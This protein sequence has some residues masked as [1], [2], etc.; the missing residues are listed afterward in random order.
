MFKQLVQKKIVFE[1]FEVRRCRL[2]SNQ[3]AVTSGP[4]DKSGQ[5]CIH[6]N[7]MHIVMRSWSVQRASTMLWIQIVELC[8]MQKNM[9]KNMEHNVKH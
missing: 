2:I 9:Q 3:R 5:F 8:I 6:L 7:T 1:V 4:R